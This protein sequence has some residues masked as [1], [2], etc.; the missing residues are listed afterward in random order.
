MVTREMQQ[1]MTGMKETREMRQ[2]MQREM[3][4]MRQAMQEMRDMGASPGEIRRE[5]GHLAKRWTI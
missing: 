5:I 1:E 4:K 2:V 3:R